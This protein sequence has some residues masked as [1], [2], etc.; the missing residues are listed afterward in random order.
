MGKLMLLEQ[1]H[2]ARRLAIEHHKGQTENAGLPYIEHIYRVVYAVST[3]P[4]MTVAYLHDIVEDTEVTLMDLRAHGFDDNVLD[5]VFLLTRNSHMTYMEYIEQVSF[6]VL[7]RTVKLADIRDHL[8]DPTVIGDK[9]VWRYIK[10]L[11]V[12]LETQSLPPG[13]SVPVNQKAW[14]GGAD[15]GSA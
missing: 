2:L 1:L 13:L 14:K 3:I 11:R 4:E 7:A 15:D 5:A 12:L 6:G 8:R 9:L 10:A